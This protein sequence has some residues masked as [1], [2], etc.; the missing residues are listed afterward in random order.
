SPDVQ[1]SVYA[2]IGSSYRTLGFYEKA[3]DHL[4]RALEHWE[5]QGSKRDLDRAAVLHLLALVHHERAR[6]DRDDYNQAENCYTEAQRIYRQA[7]SELALETRLMLA[8][9]FLIQEDY[10]KAREHFDGIVNGYDAS[11]KK[12]KKPDRLYYRAQ[13]GLA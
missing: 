11:G 5:S 8:W 7:G 9:L 2:V 3:E 1:A 10:D 4:N 12:G 6:L 13:I